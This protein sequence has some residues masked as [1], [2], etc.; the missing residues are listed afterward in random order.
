HR[1]VRRWL[2]RRVLFQPRVPPSVRRHAVG[3]QGADA[4]REG[5]VEP[6]GT[7]PRRAPRSLLIARRNLHRWH[8]PAELCCAKIQLIIEYYNFTYLQESS[9]AHEIYRARKGKDV[10]A[11]AAAAVAAGYTI[12]VRF[13]G[14]LNEKQKAAFKLAANRWTHVI[15]GDLPDVI[16]GGETI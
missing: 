3:D 2:R 16:V 13:L 15:T 5:G 10:S 9:M 4:R 8:D 12:E 7:Q 11:E 14:G 6:A 1:C